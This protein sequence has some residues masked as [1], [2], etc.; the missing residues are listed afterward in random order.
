M[1]FDGE[2][3]KIAEDF[4]GESV[5]VGHAIH[6][7]GGR[8]LWTIYGHTQPAGPIRGGGRV[9]KGEI[10]ATL[11]K[12][13]EKA[14]GLFTHLHLSMAWVSRAI[15]PHEV[16]W[17]TLHD[18]AISILLDPLHAMNCPYRILDPEA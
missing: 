16:S 6:N 11:T 15:A 13:D 2:I 18:P 3:I 1:M 10:I 8:R 4:L 5:Y 14:S 7:G 9:R 17:E 12:V